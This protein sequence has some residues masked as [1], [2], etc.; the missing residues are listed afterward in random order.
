MSLYEVYIT[1]GF[2][3][4]AM[5]VCQGLDHDRPMVHKFKFTEKVVYIVVYIHKGNINVYHVQTFN[6]IIFQMVVGQDFCIEF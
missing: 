6:F 5:V 1:N 3:L 2:V 4:V